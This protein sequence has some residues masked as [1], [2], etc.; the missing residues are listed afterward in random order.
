M[1]NEKTFSA[2]ARIRTHNL[3]SRSLGSLYCLL[4][5]W[6]NS[7]EK[8]TAERNYF[9]MKNIHYASFRNLRLYTGVS[10]LGAYFKVHLEEKKPMQDRSLR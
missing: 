5:E 2:L 3:T 9:I 8:L 10:N 6:L 4:F 7:G 1:S